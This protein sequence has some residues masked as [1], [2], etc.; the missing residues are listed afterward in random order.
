MHEECEQ[1]SGHVLSKRSAWYVKNSSELDHGKG[2]L[3]PLKVSFIPEQLMLKGFAQRPKSGSVAVLGFELATES[4]LSYT[5]NPK[6]N[7]KSLGL[8][9]QVPLQAPEM[10]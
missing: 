6:T 7:T 8:Y 5:N 4:F 9:E 2:E 3:A 1:S 10:N